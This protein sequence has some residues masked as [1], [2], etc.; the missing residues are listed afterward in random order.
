MDRSW[1]QS[2]CVAAGGW[3]VWEVTTD[4][5]EV[6]SGLGKLLQN[7]TCWWLDSTVTLLKSRP[8]T[9]IWLNCVAFELHVNKA[10]MRLIAKGEWDGWGVWGS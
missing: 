1:T 7:G 4:R 10:I 9:L 3:E 2:R 6:S 5:H 8:F